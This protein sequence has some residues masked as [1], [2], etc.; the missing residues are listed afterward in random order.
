MYRFIF[1]EKRVYKHFYSRFLISGVDLARIRRV[2]SRIKNFYNW[3]LEWSKEG[4]MLEKLAEEHQSKNNI[5]TARRLFHEAAGCFHIAQHIYFIDIAQKNE[6]QEKAR[7]A[8]RKAIE[9]YDKKQRPIGIAIP[10]QETMIPGYL[11]LSNQPNEPLI[12]QINGLDNLKEIENHYL[13]NLLLDAR[14]NVFSF[15]G[16]GQG[17]M[18]KDMKLIPDYE[19]VVSTIINWFEVNNKYDMNLAKIG[20]IGMSFGGYLSPRVASFEKRIVCAVS[21]G[22]LGYLKK[23]PKKINPIWVKDF[24]HVTG[25]K[26]IEEALTQGK[27]D[28]KEAPPLNRPLL[29]IHGGKDKLIPNSKEQVDYIMDWAIGEKEL[30]FYPDGEHCCV[31]YMDEVL[32]YVIDWFKKHLSN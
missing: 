3:C 19:K 28:I 25:F 10:F 20:T 8:Y 9:L 29:I 2:V 18:W 31:N 11:R 5:F 6:A 26:S 24:L 14:F 22:G 27:I 7:N 15:D 30:K 17:E 32:P 21:I 4:T 23:K 12:I 13:G 16:P 1:N